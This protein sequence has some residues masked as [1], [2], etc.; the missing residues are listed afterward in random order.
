MLFF[1]QNKLQMVQVDE[2]LVGRKTPLTIVDPHY[3]SRHPMKPPY[4]DGYKE[5]LFALGCF[6]GAER[7]FWQIKGVYVTAVGYA[8][9]FTSNPTYEE[10]C[11]G[12][13]GHAEAVHIVYDPNVVAYRDLLVTFWSCHNPTQGFRQGNDIGT[14]YRSVVFVL[15]DDQMALAKDTR[16]EYQ[17]LINR[18]GI[19]G[20]ITTEIVEGS[21]FFYAEQEHQQYLAKNPS[22]YCGL[23]GLGICLD[24]N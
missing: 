21:V 8:G 9:G 13:T 1:K 17:D 7:V 15:S 6:W 14:Q 19:E 10:V 5:A 18:Q 23:G 16:Q 22:G 24:Q 2:A 12:L 20:V 4:P 3:V 11:T